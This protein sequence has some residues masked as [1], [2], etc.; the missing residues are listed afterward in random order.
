[1]RRPIFKSPAEGLGGIDGGTT[2]VG[3]EGTRD[4]SSGTQEV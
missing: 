4:V 3:R 1:M 2:F